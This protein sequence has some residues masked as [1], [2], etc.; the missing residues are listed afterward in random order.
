MT[1]AAQLFNG[2]EKPLNINIEGNLNFVGNKLPV[3]AFQTKTFACP[4]CKG[5]TFALFKEKYRHVCFCLDA[6]CLKVDS[7]ASKAVLHGKPVK[8]FKKETGAEHFHL[9]KL[10]HDAALS[11]W[12]ASSD[13][14]KR[15]QSW[16]SN[17]KTFFLAMGT[18]GTGKTYLSAGILNILYDTNVEVYY[19]THRR[20]IEDIHRSM[21]NGKT[22]HEVIPKYSEKK[23]LIFDDLGS[24][25]CT[26]WQQEMLL[27]LI[28]R[29]YSNKEKTV[30]T[31]NLNK[32]ELYQKL[33][34]R[35]ASRLL[36]SNNEIMEFWSTDRRSTP[37]FDS[38]QWW[39]K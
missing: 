15:V 23:F 19:T 7:D 1:L 39:Q 17:D 9:G 24:A 38:E 14:H 3:Q 20:F 30:I 33:G 12:I 13:E 32:D 4:R 28:D 10:F 31:T 29:R 27:E 5:N 6:K 22:Q 35:T 21:Q 2:T 34:K 25:T 8:D 37:G 18:Q 16:I 26:E 11:K 36:D